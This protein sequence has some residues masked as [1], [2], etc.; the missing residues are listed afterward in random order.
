MKDTTLLVAS[1]RGDGNTWSF[2]EKIKATDKCEIL[3]L[4]ELQISYF[5]YEQ[6]NTGDDFLATIEEIC[7]YRT[8][9]FVSPVYWYT[10]SAQMKTFIDRLSD[11]LVSRKDLGRELAGKQTFLLA[12]GATDDSLPQGMEDCIKLTSE[13]MDMQFLGSFY[14]KVRGERLFDEEQLSRASDFLQRVCSGSA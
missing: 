12:T 1:S 3:N 8:I 10:V 6:K 11:L 9:G 7:A 5:D 13:Y 4:S 2:L 14:L